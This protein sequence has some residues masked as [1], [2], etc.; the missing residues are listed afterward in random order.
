MRIF[1]FL[2][3]G[4]RSKLALVPLAVLSPL[5]CLAPARASATRSSWPDQSTQ[6]GHST[7]TLAPSRPPCPRI[8]SLLRDLGL[9]EHRLRR[10]WQWRCRWDKPCDRGHL[11]WFPLQRRSYLALLVTSSNGSYT[12]HSPS[13]GT[14]RSNHVPRPPH[15]DLRRVHRQRRHGQR[16]RARLLSFAEAAAVPLVALAAWQ[17][18]VDVAHVRPGQRVLVHAGAGGLGSTVV[19]VARHLGLHEAT[20]RPLSEQPALTPRLRRGQFESSL[21]Q[22]ST[23]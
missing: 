1:R 22:L 6:P 7:A 19:Q 5:R 20:T 3:S 18:L 23:R 10:S 17:A 12:C 11:G 2:C 16:A 15:R 9:W 8:P 13:F 4:G 14:H 21:R